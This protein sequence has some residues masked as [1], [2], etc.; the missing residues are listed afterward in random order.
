MGFSIEL[1]TVRVLTEGLTPPPSL[2]RGGTAAFA[3]WI[4]EP[5]GAVFFV[6]LWKNSEWDTDLAITT[7]DSSGNW[8][9]PG[10]YGGGGWWNPF[11]RP[12]EGWEGNPILWGG[13]SSRDLGED[14]QEELLVRVIDGMASTRVA[15]LEVHDAE[16]NLF[17]VVDIREDTGVFLVGV[18][19]GGLYTISAFGGDGSILQDGQGREVRDV[20]DPPEEDFPFDLLHRLSSDE[21]GMALEF[22]RDSNGLYIET[23]E[24]KRRLED[25]EIVAHFEKAL[26]RPERPRRLG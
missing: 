2:E 8:L 21:D 7:Q 1:E 15:R 12:V 23:K 5:Y 18:L 19:G 4:H 9:E 22:F 10:G 25:P 14:D 6:R 26:N 16:G 11:D 24:G 17:D 20:F 3:R 13:E